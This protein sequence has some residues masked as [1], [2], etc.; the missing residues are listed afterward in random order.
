MQHK[1]SMKD[2]QQYNVNKLNKYQLQ[3]GR[4]DSHRPQPRSP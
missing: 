1:L 2:E 4:Q 3:A